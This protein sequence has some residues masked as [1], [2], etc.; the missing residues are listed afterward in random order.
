M[1]YRHSRV[2]PSVFDGSGAT[3]RVFPGAVMLSK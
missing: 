1:A 2:T 3:E